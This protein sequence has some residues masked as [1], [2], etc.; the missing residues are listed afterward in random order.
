MFAVAPILIAR[1]PYESTMGLV[2]KIF[3]LPRAARNV[4]FLSAFVCGIASAA[5]S[6][7]SGAPRADRVALAAAE[8]TVLF[9]LIGLVTGPA[10]GAEGLGRLVAVGRAADHGAAAVDDLRRVS[11]AAPLRRARIGQAQPR[12]V[13]LFGMANVPFV[14]VSVN[15]WRT[16]HPKT[17]VVPTLRAGHA[18]S[19]LVLRGAFLLLFGVLLALRVRLA[20]QQAELERL[21]LEP[22]M[23][24]AVVMKKRN[25]V[26]RCAMSLVLVG[27]L[28]VCRAG[29]WRASGQQP[30]GADR[31]GAE[32]YVPVE[33]PPAGG[34][35]ARGAASA[36]GL[37]ARSGSA[38]SSTCG[39]SGGGW[40]PSSASCGVLP[41]MVDT[42]R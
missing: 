7:S 2:Q 41:R 10:V 39:R 19:L 15:V 34:A 33:G 22:T 16:V 3:Y 13:A 28:R 38:C 31:G 20:T 6:S 30:G 5:S 25:G 12:R 8:L 32:G 27:L 14:Y 17:N 29:R 1:A 24:G 26:R 40:R 37:C 36:R 4:M 18:G 11:A 9:G 35:V 21:Y 42:R 23:N